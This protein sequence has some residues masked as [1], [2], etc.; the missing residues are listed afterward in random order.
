MTVP[1]MMPPAVADIPGEMAVPV[2][3]AMVAVPAGVSVVVMAVMM[4]V[5]QRR[6]RGLPVRGSRA[7]DGGQQDG[8]KHGKPPLFS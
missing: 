7:Q 4:V 1:A 5:G 2:M 8:T 6:L 3:A